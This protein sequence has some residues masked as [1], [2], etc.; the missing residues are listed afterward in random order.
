MG[1]VGGSASDLSCLNNSIRRCRAPFETLP[2][3]VAHRTTTSTAGPS[4]N[5]CN[6]A[7]YA[8]QLD[9]FISRCHP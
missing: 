7:G 8:R 9:H 5:R 2:S 4:A 6:G 1:L 3:A